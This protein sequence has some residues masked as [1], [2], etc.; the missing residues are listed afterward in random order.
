MISHEKTR[1]RKNKGDIDRVNDYDKLDDA[2]VTKYRALV[3]FE[4]ITWLLIVV[5]LPSVSR[6]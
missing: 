4:Q 6:S 1:N 2:Q 5:T 3:W